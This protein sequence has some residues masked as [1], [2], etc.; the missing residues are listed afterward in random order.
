MKNLIKQI[1]ICL[2]ALVTFGRVT[3]ADEQFTEEPI[4][5]TSHFQ[6]MHQNAQIELIDQ[7]PASFKQIKPWYA[8]DGQHYIKILQ[9]DTK[10]EG[11]MILQIFIPSMNKSPIL[12]IVS[13]FKDAGD[14]YWLDLHRI[15]IPVFWGRIA[16]T[17]FMVDVDSGKII[18]IRDIDHG[19]ATVPHEQACSAN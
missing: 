16:E 11:P 9:P 7:I 17:D 5:K 10:K 19:P 13:D 1:F 4:C 12:F 6:L 14:V 2:L 3:M 18:D 8:P 15:M